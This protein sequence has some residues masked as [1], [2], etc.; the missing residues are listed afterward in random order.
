VGLIPGFTHAS[1][2][3]L[4]FIFFRAFIEQEAV[5][6]GVLMF[7]MR[8]RVRGGVYS[9]CIHGGH[10]NATVATVASAVAHVPQLTTVSE[11]GTT[12]LIK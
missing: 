3:S 8:L 7:A 9:L 11:M 12:I 1:Y 6:S 5:A 4:L 2:F 10:N